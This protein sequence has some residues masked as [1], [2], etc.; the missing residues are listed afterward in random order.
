MSPLTN[1]VAIVTGAGAGI[2]R[3]IVEALLQQNCTVAMLDREQ[4]LLERASEELKST[5]IPDRI[6]LFEVDVREGR[7]L[8]KIAEEVA[9]PQGKID[10]VV[11]CAGIVRVGPFCD[12]TED[13]WR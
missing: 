11:N 5:G 3:C 10:I 13:E 4:A 2:G 12:I 9:G 6:R 1:Q 8:R 7:E